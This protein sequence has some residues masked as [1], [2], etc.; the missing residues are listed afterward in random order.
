MCSGF[1]IKTGLNRVNGHSGSGE[2]W[3]Y[4][5]PGVRSLLDGPEGGINLHMAQSVS[6]STTVTI[7][8]SFWSSSFILLIE[9]N[10]VCLFVCCVF[11]ASI[12]SI[13]KVFPERCN[14]NFKFS[15]KSCKF[16]CDIW[17]WF[18]VGYFDDESEQFKE[19]LLCNN[20]FDWYR[21]RRINHNTE[22]GSI[23]PWVDWSACALKL[24]VI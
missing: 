23:T 21:I 10:I 22:I 12:G 19:I 13:F 17:F 14:F 24:R 7:R 11:R 3:G 9:H 4:V 8:S 5:K 16:Y 2:F 6:F 18:H 20:M 15:C 1:T